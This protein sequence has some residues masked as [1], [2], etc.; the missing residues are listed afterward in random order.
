MDE[1]VFSM[2]TILFLPI[3]IE[4]IKQTRNENMS[5]NNIVSYSIIQNINM[6]YHIEFYIILRLIMVNP[7]AEMAF[8]AV[9]TS[10]ILHSEID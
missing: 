7:V 9:I 6:I 2:L 5:I 3:I 8:V 4:Q 1:N 10:Y